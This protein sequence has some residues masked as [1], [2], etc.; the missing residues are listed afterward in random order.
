MLLTGYCTLAYWEGGG[1]GGIIAFYL[2]FYI[3][4]LLYICVVVCTSM[5]NIYFA[6]VHITFAACFSLLT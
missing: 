6:L 5:T 4:S 1:G 2:N 3:Q